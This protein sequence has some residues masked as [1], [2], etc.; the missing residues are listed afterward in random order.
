MEN[1]IRVDVA[2]RRQLAVLTIV[3]FIFSGGN[4]IM[5]PLWNSPN[6]FNRDNGVEF[7]REK[8]DAAKAC[9]GGILFEVQI[10]IDLGPAPIFSNK[11]C[12][13][14]YYI[15]E[16]RFATIGI[17]KCS[18]TALSTN[19]P[20]H[21]YSQHIVLKISNDD[22][23]DFTP[24]NY[25]YYTE[26]Y[27]TGAYLG[28]TCIEQAVQRLVIDTVGGGILH[29][30]NNA[31]KLDEYVADICLDYAAGA[32]THEYYMS[33]IKW[34]KFYASLNHQSVNIIEINQVAKGNKTEIS[35]P[36]VDKFGK[37]AEDTP[38]WFQ[39][40]FPVTPHMH[41]VFWDGRSFYIPNA[42][43]IHERA[44]RVYAPFGFMAVRAVI[45]A[46]GQYAALI[47]LNATVAYGKWMEYPPPDPEGANR[48][49]EG[50][51]KDKWWEFG[52]NEIERQGRNQ[53]QA[54]TK[55]IYWT[56]LIARPK[57]YL[58]KEDAIRLGQKMEQ[59]DLF[60]LAK[61]FT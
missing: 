14:Y 30:N 56:G 53:A 3:F 22:A 27:G 38:E 13:I 41:M 32:A 46:V 18:D 36:Y 34:S 55:G 28:N 17:V 48:L 5:K 47:P 43:Q 8:I 25:K 10:N 45:D 42:M 24:P 60:N 39:G 33:Q 31:L 21:F 35:E 59:T 2:I 23:D 37:G 9:A 40:A 7:T 6:V 49:W 26:E 51:K 61:M 16:N 44:T 19:I 52:I 57:I 12:R 54:G 4:S 15:L 58:N 11:Q 29:Y 1:D 20:T 50:D